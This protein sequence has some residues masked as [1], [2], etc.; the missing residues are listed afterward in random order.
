MLLLRRVAAASLPL[1][2]A[3]AISACFSGSTSSSSGRAGHRRPRSATTSGTGGASTAS[4]SAGTAGATTT[5]ASV[6][7][8]GAGG[9]GPGDAG[10]SD[11]DILDASDESLGKGGL[12][13]GVACG[14]SAASPDAGTCGLDLSCCYPC[15]EQMCDSVCTISCNPHQ[16]GCMGGCIPQ[17]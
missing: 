11:A 6:G 14:S 1:A 12:K 13:L 3:A 5:S 17:L 4:G 7:V 2:L 8:G 16:S 15:K 10:P 9:A